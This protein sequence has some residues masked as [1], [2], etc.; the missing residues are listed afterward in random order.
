MNINDIKGWDTYSS[1]YTDFID[2]LTKPAI[3]IE[4]GVFLGKGL[5]KAALHAKN[6][7]KDVK[8]YAVDTWEGSDEPEHKEF[9]KEIGGP[10]AFYNQFL[11][12]LKIFDVNDII[13]P[14]RGKSVET[15][16]DFVYNKGI[17]ADLVFLDASHDYKS[18][19]EDILAWYPVVQNGGILA[20]HDIHFPD[21]KKAI[22]EIL[23]RYDDRNDSWI[24]HK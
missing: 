18:V 17:R 7:K 12:N 8:M 9:L 23:I 20:G 1:I 5:I 13:L 10:E 4:V 2:D 16:N 6:T 19:K 15:A 3:L 22:S 14:I 21:V 24:Y 11:E